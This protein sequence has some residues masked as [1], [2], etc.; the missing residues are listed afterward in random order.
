MVYIIIYRPRP[1]GLHHHLQT[2]APAA[3]VQVRHLKLT[4]LV[5]ADDICLLASSH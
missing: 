2:A 4:N 3:G 5:Y 1:H